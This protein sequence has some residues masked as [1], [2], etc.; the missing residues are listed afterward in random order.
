[1]PDTYRRIQEA[2][3]KSCERLNGHG[4]A[5]AQVYNHIILP[6]ATPEDRKT[7]IRWGVKDFEF[8]F[9]RKPEA[10]WLAETAINMDTMRDLIEEGIRYVILSP[11]QAES[12]RKIGDSEWKGCANTD[13]DTTRPYR[14]F[15]RD[16]NELPVVVNVEFKPL[17]GDELAE[18]IGRLR[19]SGNPHAQK[20]QYGNRL[21]HYSTF[22]VYSMSQLDLVSII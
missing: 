20:K 19:V 21:A 17:A 12:F 8:H 14:I 15:P 6:L 7:Q 10:I 22:Q 9:G 11:T 4:N 1:M 18:R 3:K 13:I 5:I 16:P 2:D